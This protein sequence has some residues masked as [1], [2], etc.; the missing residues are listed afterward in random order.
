[1]SRKFERQRRIVTE[2]TANSSI[3]ISELAR[4]LNVSKQTIRRDLDELSTSGAIN[5]TYGGA[6]A[7]PMGFEPPMDERGQM[8]R[9]EK[10]A[11]SERACGLFED[12]EVIMMG[13][14]VTMTHLARRLAGR[15]TRLQVFTNSVTVGKVL[16]G[17]PGI[18]V[19]LAPG[20]FDAAEGCVCGAETLEFLEKFRADTMVFSA[21]GIYEGGACEVHSGIAWV[22]RVMARCT[23]RRILLI[24]HSKFDQPQLELIVPFSQ[25]DAIVVDRPPEGELLE[26]IRAANTELIIAPVHESEPVADAAV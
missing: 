4:Q 10:N 23:R 14:G 9:A 7:R 18:R 19:V 24:D 11:V 22:E 15:P 6:T 13:T 26:A 3:R 25:I 1:M 12:N 21:S 17:N 5:R 20:D 16:S 2:L 8:L